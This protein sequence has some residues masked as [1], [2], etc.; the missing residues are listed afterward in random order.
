MI[1]GSGGHFGER[2][3]VCGRVFSVDVD[4]VLPGEQA[5]LTPLGYDRPAHM[6]DERGERDTRQC[7]KSLLGLAHGVS[8]GRDM[9]I[10]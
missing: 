3:L 5:G 1:V 4:A 8:P 10:S 9:L 2:D 7:Q 6:S